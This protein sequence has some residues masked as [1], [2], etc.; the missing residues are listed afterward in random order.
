MADNNVFSWDSFIEDD[1]KGKI[2]IL[3][4]GNY[5][6]TVSEFERA[7]F[8]G[9]SKIPACPQAN[10]TLDVLTTEGT[11][12][13]FVKLQL[14][15]AVEWKLSSFFRSIGSKKHGEKMKMDWS[16]V[17]GKS[18]VAHFKP[19]QYEKNGENRYANDVEFF[20]DYDASIISLKPAT[21]VSIKADVNSSM[22]ELNDSESEDIPF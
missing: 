19:R 17:K 1:G 9:S 10:L 11:A 18:G 15:Q 13:C 8:P 21:I 16:K 20:C 6:F 2:I 14:A 5:T 4:E 7:S 12:K 3:P 22:S